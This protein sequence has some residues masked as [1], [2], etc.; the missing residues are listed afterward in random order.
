MSHPPKLALEPVISA[1]EL[2]A[3][4]VG[5]SVRVSIAIPGGIAIG[6]LAGAIAWG[7][8]RLTHHAS[9]PALLAVI[10]IVGISAI[11]VLIISPVWSPRWLALN[12]LRRTYMNEERHLWS[13][14]STLTNSLNH[15]RKYQERLDEQ[16]RAVEP[17]RIEA[18]KEALSN[19]RDF[20][21]T[22]RLRAA[23]IAPRICDRVGHQTVTTLRGH[24]IHSAYD[25]LRARNLQ[26]LHGIGPT[27]EAN[28][29]QWARTVQQ[30]IDCSSQAITASLTAQAAIID[31]EATDRLKAI[32]IN[33][34]KAQIEQ[35]RLE[36][37]LQPF[38]I[39]LNKCRAK[40]RVM[41]KEIV[42]QHEI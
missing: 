26:E 8:L 36:Q 3:A 1:R 10:C 12:R 30:S 17:A 18:H 29:K 16:S 41:I 24:G 25:V 21:V 38:A 4:N 9:T 28:L 15:C 32:A 19:V 23:A 40:F 5:L 6:A 27:V 34:S 14:Q 2:R 22:Q 7:A 20:F 33:R 11:A 35:Q 13:E 39:E 31:A 42:D 37:Q